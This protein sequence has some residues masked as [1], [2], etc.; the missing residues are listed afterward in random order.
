MG[1]ARNQW[2]VVVDDCSFVNTPPLNRNQPCE[3]CIT[4]SSP[5]QKTRLTVMRLPER[6]TSGGWWRK[7][8]STSPES[9]CTSMRVT[10][11]SALPT[12]SKCVSVL[13]LKRSKIS[14]SSIPSK[15]RSTRTNCN[16][17]EG[18]TSGPDRHAVEQ[19]QCI[20]SFGQ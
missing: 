16:L 1:C 9:V 13:A 14:L 17:P 7:S 15:S 18:V 12:S 19:A 5:C 4:T 8:Y 2:Y 10:L 20:G 6:C 3:L 11:S